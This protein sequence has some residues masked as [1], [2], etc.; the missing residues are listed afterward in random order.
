MTP[1]ILYTHTDEAP[2]LATYSLLPVIQAFADAAGATVETRD[3]SLAGRILANFPDD[4]RPDQRVGDA[5]TELGEIA[6]TPE[7]N[8]IKLPN[9]SASVPQMKAAVAELQA[10][11]YDVPDFPDEPSTPEEREIRATFDKVMG[12]AVNPVLRQGNSDRRAPRAVKRYAQK[13]PHSMG[14]WSPDSATHVATMGADDFRS[15]EQSLTVD[16]P[17]TLR[18]EHVAADGTVE[19]LKEVP[20]LADEVVDSTVMR[21]A[22]ALVGTQMLREV[23]QDAAGE[24]DV[25]CLDRRAGGVGEGLDD[26]QQRVRGQR[27]RLVG[28]RVQDLGS[29]GDSCSWGCRRSGRT[30]L[31]LVWTIARWRPFRNRR[32]PDVYAPGRWISHGPTTSSSCGDSPARS[33]A[34]RW[35]PTAGPTIRGSTATPRSSP[36]AWPSSAGSA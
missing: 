29:H 8:I 12:S 28:V 24:G 25:A 9:I 7:A 14:K 31:Q 18:I 26:R 4:L 19:V 35:P 22:D 11:G 10:K 6:L 33:P 34:R 36:C 2:A 32:R 17:T 23:G 15:N 16:E 3:I 13:H 21:V 1:K 20:V 30:C 5:L 27:R